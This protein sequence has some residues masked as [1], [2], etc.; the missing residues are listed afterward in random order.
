MLDRNTDRMWYVIGA[1]LIGAAIIFGM[2]T[3][4]PNAF[5]SV[6]GLFDEAI[7][8]TDDVMDRR[9]Y[10]NR[11]YKTDGINHAENRFKYNTTLYWADGQ[12]HTESDYWAEDR[13]VIDYIPVEPGERY[14]IYF[15]NIDYSLA[16]D[17]FLG[18][19]YYNDDKEYLGS[20]FQQPF[21]DLSV[22]EGDTPYGYL[23]GSSLGVNKPTSNPNPEPA[24]MRF[25]LNRVMSKSDIAVEDMGIRIE[26][27]IDE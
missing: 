26:K 7:S 17:I 20:F 3:L 1:V 15:D 25:V 16:K 19:F 10:D 27:L 6:S 24:Y 9:M 5:A 21:W 23:K 2:N 22:P 4:M 8:Q 11:Q 12:E 13:V 18:G 14:V